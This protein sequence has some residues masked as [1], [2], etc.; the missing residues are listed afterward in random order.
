M[1]I[2]IGITT[3][4]REDYL[5][6]FVSSLYKSKGINSCSINVFDDCSSSWDI[7]YLKNKFPNASNII[8]N[9][10]NL[11]SDENIRQMFIH[12]LESGDDIFVAIDS[13]FIFHPLW[14]EFI[15]NNINLT[16]GIFSL[17]NSSCHQPII[18]KKSQEGFKFIEKEHIGSACV[19]MRRNVVHDIIDKVP[20]SDFYDWD[21]SKYLFLKGIRILVSIRSYAQ[22]IGIY[23]Y[24]NNGIYADYGLGF[25]SGNEENEIINSKLF[26]DLL[27]I[28]IDALKGKE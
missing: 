27:K 5:N 12:F 21:W 10:E 1:K 25:I 15:I 16:D 4:E 17:Y 23:G 14:I 2:Y 24:N 18:Q 28:H 20:K 26:E 8:R 19:V 3:F 7:T 22:H 13:D 11:G 6:V 9:E